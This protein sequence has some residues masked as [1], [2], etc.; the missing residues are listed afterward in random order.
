MAAASSPPYSLAGRVAIV[1]GSSRGIGRAIAIHLAELGAKVVI[2]YTTRSTDADQVA[3]EIN[4]STGAGP[5]PVAVV[6]RAD[7]WDSSHVESLFDA[8][9]KAFNSPVHILVNSAGIVD[10]NYPTIA[11]TPIDDFNRIFRSNFV[12]FTLSEYQ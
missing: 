9:E 7:I 12:S 1:T 3:A 5:E 2:N 6:F 4:S 10:P 8:A 11:N